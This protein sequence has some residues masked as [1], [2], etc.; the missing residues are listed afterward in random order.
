MFH[1]KIR[2]IFPVGKGLFSDIY[3]KNLCLDGSIFILG[4]LFEVTIQE[5]PIPREEI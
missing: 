2:E 1:G 3:E 5:Y 4:A